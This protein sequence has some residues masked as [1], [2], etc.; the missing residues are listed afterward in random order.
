MVNSSISK[1]LLYRNDLPILFAHL[2]LGLNLVL[3]IL[4]VEG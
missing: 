2:I 1:C 4:L 3:L